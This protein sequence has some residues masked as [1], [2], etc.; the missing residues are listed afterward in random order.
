MLEMLRENTLVVICTDVD[1]NQ[2]PEEFTNS[3]VDGYHRISDLLW[4]FSNE[5]QGLD[6][7]LMELPN[8]YLLPFGYHSIP[9]QQLTRAKRLLKQKLGRNLVI[10]PQ[11]VRM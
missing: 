10:E 1:N 9:K 6:R 4:V 7:S 5:K 2:L 11:R 3:V 8:I